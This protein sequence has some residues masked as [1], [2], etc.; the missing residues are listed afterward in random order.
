MKLSNSTY[1]VFCD[2][3]LRQ[4]MYDIILHAGQYSWLDKDTYQVKPYLN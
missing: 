4:A 2:V 3:Y 1:F